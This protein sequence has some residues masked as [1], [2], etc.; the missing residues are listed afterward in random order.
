M[1]HSPPLSETDSPIGA[2]TIN[3]QNT[4]ITLD[5]IDDTQTLDG[6]LNDTQKLLE[7]KGI[8]IEHNEQTPDK[9]TFS[10]FDDLEG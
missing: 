3:E 10:F 5:D 2:N 8:T 7:N 6:F 1:I 9:K 4:T